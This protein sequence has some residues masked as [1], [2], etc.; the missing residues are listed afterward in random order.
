M[1][2]RLFTTGSVAS[3]IYNKM[4]YNF[5]VKQWQWTRLWPFKIHSQDLQPYMAL[6]LYGEKCSLLTNTS[7]EHPFLHESYLFTLM[8]FK[9]VFDFVSAVLCSFN[10]PINVVWLPKFF[11]ISFLQK[12]TVILWFI[13]I[14]FLFLDELSPGAIIVCTWHIANYLVVIQKLRQTAKMLIYT[15]SVL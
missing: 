2:F 5:F 11:K 3:H 12:T 15:H 8:W 10:G 9:P 14:W 7:Y 6:N 1:M 13:L 4:F